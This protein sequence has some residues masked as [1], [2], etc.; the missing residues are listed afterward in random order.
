M[1]NFS[2]VDVH[3]DSG[4]H[5]HF[6]PHVFFWL[7]IVRRRRTR[8]RQTANYLASSR[9]SAFRRPHR[10]PII[11]STMDA[12]DNINVASF[13]PPAADAKRSAA[14]TA[15]KRAISEAA[16]DGMQIDEATGIEGAVRT[17]APKTKRKKHSSLELRK[18]QVPSHR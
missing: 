8:Q 15:K 3:S 5:G 11:P 4:F 10:L 12:A 18:I 16:D 6:F 2:F 7:Y 14:S 9:A 17:N 13:L 1:A